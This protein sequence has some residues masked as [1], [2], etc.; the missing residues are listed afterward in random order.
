MVKIKVSS[1]LERPIIPEKPIKIVREHLIDWEIVF[2]VLRIESKLERKRKN[3][4]SLKLL[5]YTGF[6]KMP[7][8]V[9]NALIKGYSYIQTAITKRA[10]PI[11]LH[12]R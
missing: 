9:Q 8:L 5:W 11:L 7:T 10:P 1:E 4:F 2:P 12:I 6:E 3:Y